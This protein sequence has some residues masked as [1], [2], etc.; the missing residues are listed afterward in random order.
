VNFHGTFQ[1]G[2]GVGVRV[3]GGEE[4]RDGIDLLGWAFTRSLADH[5]PI[6]GSFYSGDLELLRGVGIPLPTV[7]REKTEWGANLEARF[8]GLN[9]FAQYVHQKVAGFVRKGEE[10]E[11]AWRIPLNGVF[12]SGDTPV[13][14]WIAPTVR[15]S[16][17]GNDI[18]LPA[19]FVDPSMTWSWYK[20][21]FGFR[22][23]ILR[24]VDLT[25]EYARHDAILKTRV[26][27]PDELLVTLRAA[28]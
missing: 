6:R 16:H 2:G 1:Y 9:L 18:P 15:F 17:I 26:I 8:A 12:V 19:G 23:G 24:G 7:G 27:H 10:A 28:Y 4:D 25:A 11:L 22:L 20:Y 21:D 3:L 5:V 13:L 14:N